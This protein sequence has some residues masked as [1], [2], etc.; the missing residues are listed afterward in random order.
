MFNPDKRDVTANQVLAHGSLPVEIAY[1]IASYCEYMKSKGLDQQSFGQ[2]IVQINGLMETVSICERVLRDP[3]PVAYN[4]VVSQ[5]VWVFMFFL[6]FQLQLTLH[7]ISIPATL[8]T[9]AMLFGLAEIGL[10]IENPFG[11]DSNDLDTDRFAQYIVLELDT[12][13]AHPPVRKEVWVQHLE[14]QPLFPFKKHS[15]ETL[16]HQSRAEVQSLL[17]SKALS[18]QHNDVLKPRSFYDT[19]TSQ[20]RR[21]SCGCPTVMCLHNANVSTSEYSQLKGEDAEIKISR[22]ETSV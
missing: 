8:V 13:T 18:L 7:W 6:P 11:D 21:E 9:A 20:L 5:L 17:S 12:L 14:N 16:Q 2:T 19:L 3:V 22:V 15:F 10:E 1:H 4:I